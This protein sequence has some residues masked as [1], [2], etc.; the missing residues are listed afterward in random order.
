M[1]T[2]I[3]SATKT[4]NGLLEDWTIINELLVVWLVVVQ[5]PLAVWLLSKRQ[6]TRSDAERPE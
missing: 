2:N 1:N 3:D 4:V 6:L 5:P